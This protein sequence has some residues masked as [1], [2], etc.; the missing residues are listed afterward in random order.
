MT[1]HEGGEGPGS[2]PGPHAPSPTGR[3]PEPR[4]TV[5]DARVVSLPAR[6]APRYRAEVRFGVLGTL[7]VQDGDGALVR[8]GGPARRRL[9]AALVSRVGR[10]VPVDVLIDD[11][12]SDAPPMTAEKTLQ[13]HVVRLRD[14]LGRGDQGSPLVTEA[15][16]YR[17]AVDPSG[18][19]SWCFQRDLDQGRAALAAGDP[20]AALALLEQSLSWWRGEAY[21][22]FPD[23][24]FAVSERLRLSELRAIAQEAQADAAL[25]LGAGADLVPELE[26][27]V[28]HEPYRERSWEQLVTALYRAGRQGDAL[29]AYRRARTRL[30][31]DLGLEPSPSLRDLESRV[32]D[33]DPSL[34]PV[35]HAPLVHLPVAAR[36]RGEAT[37][38]ATA[39][40]LPAHPATPLEATAVAEVPPVVPTCPFPGLRPYEEDDAAVFVGRERLTAQVAGRLVD[41]DLVVLVGPSGAGKSSLARAGLV[42]ALRAG[43]IPGSAGWRISVLTPGCDPTSALGGSF[44]D[45][46]VIDQAEVLFTLS[47]APDL[48]SVDS[49]LRHLLATGSRLVLCVRADFY[50]RLAELRTFA[51]R[52]G[53]ATVLVGPLNEEETRRAVVVPA[54][55]AGVA[56]RSALV[57]Q[58]LDDVRGQ[59]GWL[60]LLSA[61]L[62]RAWD[63]RT[64]DQL[65]LEDYRAGGGVLG[66]LEAMAEEAYLAL[67]PDARPAARRILLRLATRVAGTW[68]RRPLAIREVVLPDD[69]PAAEALRH[70]VSWRLVTIGAETVELAHEALLT[71]WPR[72]D[73]WLDERAVVAD[74]LNLL[75]AAATAWEQQARPEDDVLTGP[76]LQAALDW[77]SRHP[78]DFSPAE[79]DYLAV[80]A[81]FADRE[82]STE[83]RRRRR[84]TAAV[85]AVAAAALLATGFGTV[86]AR[87]RGLADASALTADARRLAAESY[88]TPDE[89][90]AL[91]TAAASFREQDSLDSRGAL[92]NAVSKDGGAL[93]R[94]QTR[95]RL[96]WVGVPRDG[97]HIDVMDNN[98]DVIELDA[99]THAQVT[100]FHL[101]GDTVAGLAPD[102]RTLVSCGP[103]YGGGASGRV[104]V[105][106][107]DGATVRTLPTLGSETPVPQ[108]CGA[109]TGDGRWYVLDALVPDAAGR[110]PDPGSEGN[111]IAVFDTGDWAASPRLV[112]T[113]APVTALAT[114]DGSFA[115]QTADGTLQ[116]RNAADLRV[117]GIAR[118]PELA[119]DCTA[120]MCGLALS[121]DGTRLVYADPSHARSPHELLTRALSSAPTEGDPLPQDTGMFVFSADG[122]RLAAV[123]TIGTV[124]LVDPGTLRTLT[125]HTGPAVP[126]TDAA[127][128]PHGDLTELLTVGLD[129]QLVSW[130]L[131]PLPRSVTLGHI[132]PEGHGDQGLY[133]ASVVGTSDGPGTTQLIYRQDLHTGAMVSWPL[134]APPDESGAWLLANADGSRAVQ[135]LYYDSVLD[136]RH[137][138]AMHLVVY[139]LADGAV[140]LDRRWPA[141]PNPYQT[142]NAGLDAD[143]THLIVTTGPH[144]VQVVDV[145]TGALVRTL[146]VPLTGPHADK[147]WLIPLGVDHWD[148][149]VFQT[150]WHDPVAS[151]N[152]TEQG[153][154][155]VDPATGA[156]TGQVDSGHLGAGIAWSVD[157]SRA[158]IS[159]Q[160]G[161]ARVVNG[162]T[163]TALTPLV[164]VADGFASATLSPDG[165]IVMTTGTDGTVSFWDAATMTR[166]GPPVQLATSQVSAWYDLDGTVR[167]QLPPDPSHG[168][169]QAQWFS[170]PGTPQ[171]W[172]ALAC[173]FAGRDLTA[174]E[175][176]QY[177]GSLPRVA[178]CPA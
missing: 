74:Q 95:D 96:L 60:P 55:A 25:A 89:T 94:V 147:E 109:F 107:A 137:T 146:D 1:D 132:V 104:T 142:L 173:Q 69:E 167:G 152:D 5:P 145:A 112:R 30:V 168:R 52:I 155:A 17:L 51:E 56:V 141:L 42:P 36:G 99:A 45:V 101:P 53:S 29:A 80:S 164:H 64:G 123:D 162:R 77:Q 133:G 122:T 83:R 159:N 170:L 117:L 72:L 135:T 34:L 19:D 136:G 166:M 7:A 71:H 31:E 79:R 44:G 116:V 26:T 108:Q 157:G 6:S 126:V 4:L 39:V 50:S 8:L 67:D 24:T 121:P 3:G 66:A 139:D 13:S 102:G 119:V 174:A 130:D 28:L 91:L 92:Q 154:V 90:T 10:I 149:Y 43:A 9:L 115:V 20:R 62:E 128:L 49:R 46:V 41:H 150:W 37:V 35:P 148:H 15:G 171:A 98:R 40:P 54:E 58:V 23:A 84:L 169:P 88:Q 124:R 21:A 113:P 177:A 100:R 57:D 75:A 47:G 127:W 78:D 48:A 144:R 27:R 2:R 86:A 81:A 82:L 105:V 73:Q 85:A 160:A 111:A 76:R 153:I 156:L 59:P 125:D 118:R 131:S 32:L 103:A 68:V 114:G 38:A 97:S 110:T 120:S 93:W 165:S 33:Q 176:S 63:H 140:L 70:M 11:L 18:V 14:D 61:A 12:W 151:A 129:S 143:G 106:G 163:L 161:D 22:E 172:L 175:W 158:V 87:E 134:T 178:V 138:P 65:T 16:G